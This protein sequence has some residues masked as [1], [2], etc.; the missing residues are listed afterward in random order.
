MR[1]N[2]TNIVHIDS[3]DRNYSINIPIRNCANTFINFYSTTVPPEYIPEGERN[4]V[5]YNSHYKI[6][7]THCTLTDSIETNDAYIIDIS[8]P[9]NVVNQNTS[10]RMNLLIRCADNERMLE[11]LTDN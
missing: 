11:I 1:P 7:P 8:V 3:G 2:C 5:Y 4:G 10:F 9:H 6:D